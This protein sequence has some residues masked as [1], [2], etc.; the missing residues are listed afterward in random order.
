[1]YR[2]KDLST[3]KTKVMFNLT[4]RQLICFHCCLVVYLSSYKRQHRNKYCHTYND[5]SM[6]PFL[7]LL[8]MK[9]WATTG[10][11]FKALY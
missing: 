10:S 1:M 4:K 6:L 8:C 11:Y 3:V 9:T 7:C 5:F 2:T